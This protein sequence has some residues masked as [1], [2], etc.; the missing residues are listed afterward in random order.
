MPRKFSPLFSPRSFKG[1]TLTS[2]TH[3]CVCV[4]VCV[5]VSVYALL[6]QLSFVE[7]ISLSVLDDF[8]IFVENQLTTYVRICFWTLS[9]TPYV[10][11]YMM[12]W[13]CTKSNHLDCCSFAVS[14]EI[15]YYEIFNSF[16]LFKFILTILSP[17][18]YI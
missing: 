17:W 6:F 2:V 4:C 14:L 8:G 11:I 5:C 7:K 10:W 13:L 15:K 1:F 9:M 16:F 12:V 3:L 18:F